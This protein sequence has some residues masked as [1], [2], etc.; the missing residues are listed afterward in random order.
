MTSEPWFGDAVEREY[1]GMILEIVQRKTLSLNKPGFSKFS[2]NNLVIYDNQTIPG[3]NS[4]EAIDL[5]SR[6]LAGY[7]GA[8]SF[9]HVYILHDQEIHCHSKIRGE[10]LPLN[11]LWKP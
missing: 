8:A 2:E 1:A 11:D 5:C 3:M 7:W 6:K 9:D 10:P 4:V